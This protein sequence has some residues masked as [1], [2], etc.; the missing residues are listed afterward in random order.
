[1]NKKIKLLLIVPELY[2]GGAEKQFRN[3]ISHINKENLDIMVAIEHSY[4]S[5]DLQLEGQ[6]IKENK[7]V[8]FKSLQY[9]NVV[10]STYKRHVSALLINAELLP[11]LVSFRPDIVL[12]YTL[13]GLKT[14]ML[15][16]FLGS[17]CIY[18]ERNSGLYPEKFYK[19]QRAFL[20][21]TTC[22]IANSK[23]AQRNLNLHG[24]HAEYIP[25]GIEKM[26]MIPKKE[27]SEF[28]I[29]VP[30]RIARVKN[31]EILIKAIS[32]I[33]E[34]L[35]VTFIGK[36]EDTKYKTSLI[37]LAGELNVTDR[38]DFLDYTNDIIEIYANASLIVL[39]S[40]SEGFSNVILE[41]YMLGRLC[42]ASDI[43]MNRDVGA[44]GQ[45]YFK[46]DGLNEL[47]NQIVEV[48]QLPQEIADVEIDRNHEYVVRNF[49]MDNMTMMYENLIKSVG[50][51]YLKLKSACCNMIASVCRYES[52]VL[53]T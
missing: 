33:K 3:I 44:H 10:G 8:V 16:G 18:G 6:F 12:F 26:R 43:V 17:K 11:V 32:M 52:I 45:R 23:S 1:M 30:A 9:L 41:S 2:H 14:A 27:L 47:R 19:N 36:V 51:G 34:K 38:I 39:P 42:L 24:L 48:M 46:L 50:G 13:L 15:A 35:H 28:T 20:K 37:R 49:S 53:M 25:N 22:Y 4:S 5:R 7:N 40:I 21:H 29:V 31:Q